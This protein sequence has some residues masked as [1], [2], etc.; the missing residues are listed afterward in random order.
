MGMGL[1]FKTGII[2]IIAKV[3][4]GMLTYFFML[5]VLGDKYVFEMR[6]IVIRKLGRK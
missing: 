3:A 6:D 5:I 2:S 4:T 1:L